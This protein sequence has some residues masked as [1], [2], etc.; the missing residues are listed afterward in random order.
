V[1]AAEA[2]LALFGSVTIAPK[3][4]EIM[5]TIL[6]IIAAI[7]LSSCEKDDSSELQT[8][9]Y[10]GHSFILYD[11]GSYAGGMIHHPDCKCRK[12]E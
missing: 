7:A 3:T 8:I 2:S 1:K 11:G 10:E 4:N 12:H 5:K 9:Q 6:L